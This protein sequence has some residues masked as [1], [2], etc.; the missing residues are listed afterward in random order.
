MN[1]LPPTYTIENFFSTEE[2]NRICLEVFQNKNYWKKSE[3][4]P[5]FTEKKSNFQNHKNTLK[6]LL[7]QIVKFNINRLDSNSIKSCIDLIRK[8]YETTQ[9]IDNNQFFTNYIGDDE[10]MSFIVEQA[11]KWE[12]P[13]RIGVNWGSLDQQ[14]LA[15]K[16][17]STML[18]RRQNQAKKL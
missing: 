9:L 16:W 6:N 13:V 7:E 10:F 11:V 18:C 4:Y 3:K 17:I 2:I 12:K 1:H 14:L 8:Y 15:E 5:T